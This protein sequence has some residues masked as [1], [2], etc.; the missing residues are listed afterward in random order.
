MTFTNTPGSRLR[1]LF[2]VVAAA[3]PFA[4]VA[5]DAPDNE[6]VAKLLSDARTQAY[7]IRTDAE[8]MVTYTMSNTSWQSHATAV[9]LMKQHVNA[10]GATL[11]KLD[12]AKKNASP[13]QATAIDRIRPLLK[14]IAD[15]TQNA[16]SYLNK[17]PNKLTTGEYKDYIEATADQAAQL[18]SLI[19]DFVSYGN[20]KNR[21]ERLATKLEI[22]GM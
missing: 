12:D 11:A 7:Q 16:I 10:A 1:V 20:T 19:G 6:Q 9:D 17:N 15:N 3:F 18:S 14:E 21:M 4:L 2:A 8:T 5:A 22:S 13:W